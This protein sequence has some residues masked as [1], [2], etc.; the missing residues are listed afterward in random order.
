MS[1][2]IGRQPARVIIADDFTG[3]GDSAIHFAAAGLHTALLLDRTALAGTAAAH[4]AVSLATESR[5]LSP[6]DAAAETARA[7]AAAL[8]TGS[9]IAF[10][11]IDS[12]LRGNP[13]AEIEAAMDAAGFQ[14]ALI[15]PA[16]PKTGRACRDG[17]LLINDVP[18]HETG[19]G[20]DPINPVTT[21]DVAAILARQS[22]LPS[23]RLTLDEIRAGADELRKTVMKRLAEGARFLIADAVDDDDMRVLGELLRA[24]RPT[25]LPAGAGGLAEALVGE[26]RPAAESDPAERILAVTGSLTAETREQTA[27]AVA[28][29]VFFPLELDMAAALDD[30]DGEVGRLAALAAGEGEK[31]LLLTN[32]RPP[33]RN[34]EIDA[35]TAERTAK[36]FA[37]AAGE[38]CRAGKCGLLY[39]SGGSTAVAV[40]AELGLGSV[41]LV[42]ELM[43]GVVLSRCR[44]EHF[45]ATWFVSKAGGFGGPE[46]LVKLAEL[47]SRRQS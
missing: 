2:R 11:K 16:M 1:N 8:E 27:R 37:R 20:K 29:G 28:S 4:D 17:I 46:T 10:K 21:S 45:P 25:L 36:L 32:M 19:I 18:L 31:N 24:F 12:T 42:R 33:A 40:A 15:C 38:L 47:C 30:A 9:E 44:A 23:A 39:A 22:A 13:G 3:A 6:R 34:A 43:P 41:T 14:A 7:A 35:A 26:K 5:F